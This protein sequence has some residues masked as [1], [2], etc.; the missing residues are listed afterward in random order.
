MIQKRA[1]FKIIFYLVQRIF[2]APLVETNSNESI[3]IEQEVVSP[4]FIALP[5]D[6]VDGRVIMR[7]A[8]NSGAA[9][10]TLDF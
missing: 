4:L 3:A 9:I 8:N 1:V 5:S 7:E 2:D 6:L 10:S